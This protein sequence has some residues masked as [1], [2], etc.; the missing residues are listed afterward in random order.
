[1]PNTVR[2]ALS[3]DEIVETALRLA[4]QVG[5]GALSM[6]LL[7][8]ELGVWPM[9]V[10]HHVPNKEALVSLVAEA[11]LAEM[12][13]PERSTLAEPESIEDWLH[14]SRAQARAARR[15]F[16]RYPGLA[17]FILSHPPSASGMRIA[18]A[19][20][21]GLRKLGAST[22]EAARIYLTTTAMTLTLVQAETLRRQASGAGRAARIAE[23]EGAPA[24][25]FPALADSSKYFSSID[26]EARFEFGVQI[27]IDGL[28]IRLEEFQARAA[29]GQGAA[30]G[31][32]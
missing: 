14:A 5:L 13:F 26:S 11:A 16:L 15:V 32:A 25:M 6:R 9:A 29:G 4:R 12:D 20:L 23:M 19:Q 3:R 31:T 27:V 1:M 17:E 7:G 8:E 10:Y 30:A 22:E 24:E 21:S 18:E 2:R 28:R